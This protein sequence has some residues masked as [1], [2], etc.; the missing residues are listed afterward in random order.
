MLSTS[1]VARMRRLTLFGN[2]SGALGTFFYFRFL[3][4]SAHENSAAVGRAEILYF[5]AGFT[6]ISAIG[7]AAFYRW[8]RPVIRI[9]GALPA[10]PDGDELR[11]RALLVPFFF[12]LLS[13]SGW[14]AAAFI[15]GIL[16]PS[17]AGDFF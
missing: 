15:W 8:F 17:L 4:V 9:E 11:R 5:V 12:A 14:V 6:M 16:W 1:A 2:L 10:G 3:D 13:F 7:Y